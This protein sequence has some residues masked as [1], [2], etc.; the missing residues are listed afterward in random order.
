MKIKTIFVYSHTGELR[1]LNFN[2]DG[3]NV[4]TG[5]SSTGKSAL[6][7]IIEYCMGRS[8]FNVPEGV[9][10]DKVSWFGVIYQ[11]DSDQV[12]V[13]KRPPKPGASSCGLS[14]LRRGA[15]LRPPTF[16]ELEINADDDAVVT[17]LS[18]LLR[19]P[20]NRTDVPI[21][22]SRDSIAANI[23]HTL[24]YLFQKQGL[25]AN[26][27]QLFYRQNEQFQHQTIRDTLPILLG[28]SS[29]EKYELDASLREAR[30]RLK[31]KKKELFEAKDSIDTA[32]NKG[33]S[34]VSEAKAVGIINN[35]VLL[36]SPGDV[37]DALK[38]ALK[39]VPDELP[40]DDGGRI[41]SLESVLSELRVQR[42]EIE[43]KV[44]TAVQFS[45]ESNGYSNEAGEH[46]SRLKS[47]HALPKN[48]ISGEWQW[49]FS[50]KNLGMDLPIAD[51]LIE[52]LE[53]LEEEMRIVVGERPKLE[54]YIVEQKTLLDEKT[55][56]IQVREGELASAIA[57]NEAIA[58]MKSRNYAASKILGRISLFLENTKSD[59][60]VDT[61]E[62][63]CRRLKLR[64]EDLERQVGDDD[65]S[66]RIT[67]IMN[68]ISSR[69]SSYIKEFNAE[70]CEYPFRFDFKNLTVVVDR[71][72]RHIPMHRT[73]GGANHMAHHISALL[74]L[75]EFSHSNKRPIPSFL[76]I[77][78]PT[79][80]YF[81][82]EDSYKEADG[83]IEKTEMDADV[84]AVRSLFEFLNRY[85]L[86]QVAGF[87]IIV[88]EHANLRDQWFQDALVEEPW[89]KPPALIPEE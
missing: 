19:I 64:V 21:D 41:S 12:M 11:F 79:Q 81:P 14:M 27:D 85:T 72:D 3:L 8:T 78:Q 29:D 83:T 59:T 13:A 18:S 54:A 61:L 43:N 71:P 47:I 42:R 67:S 82:S 88:T 55:N 10:R 86:D 36:Q 77:D 23:K 89:G 58:E 69:L 22:H 4:I 73:G 26:K 84:A 51:V 44:E 75:H 32:Y 70:F 33:I 24:Y 37:I 68:N 52:E 63:E 35:S 25:V 38:G 2:L 1:D 45:K 5:R 87:Q 28:V 76:L 53:S 62:L 74:A 7:E 57:A 17:L 9:I 30:R 34:L 15:N 39:W 16:E 80:V 40:S 66:E 31:L 50:E 49:P 48:P 60:E 6:S 65:T 46:H 20:E 56:E